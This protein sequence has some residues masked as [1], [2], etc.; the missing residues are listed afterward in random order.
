MKHPAKRLTLQ[1]D[2][3]LDLVNQPSLF[4]FSAEERQVFKA[5]AGK[6]RQNLADL[7]GGYLV[8]GLIGGT[9]VGKSSL[10]NALAGAEIASTSHRRPHTDQVLIYRHEAMN[11]ALELSLEGVP[12]RE[13]THQ[14]EVIQQ[15]LL[16]DLPDFDSLMGEHRERVLDFLEYL[17]VVVW[18]TSPEKYADKVA[19]EFLE[20]V[21]KA[22]QNFYFV[23][24]KADIFCSGETNAVDY[25]ELGRV[26]KSYQNLIREHG[27]NEPLLF[28]LSAREA[29]GSGLLESWNQF[30]AFKQQ[31]FQQRDIK[32]IT[33][34][35]TANLDVEIQ[36]FLSVLQNEVSNL[37]AYVNILENAS[38]ETAGQRSAWVRSGEEAF[39]LW[40]KKYVRPEI[41]SEQWEPAKLIGPGYLFGILLQGR[42]RR[43]NDKKSAADLSALIVPD[44]IA[45]FFQRRLE[46][47]EDRINR[48]LLQGDL[49]ASFGGQL[50]E[51]LNVPE[52][53]VKLNEEFSIIA[54]RWV[55]EPIRSSFRGFRILQTSTYL[56]ILVL[57]LFAVGGEEAWRKVLDSFGLSSIIDLLLAG[58]QTLFSSKGL[59]ALG[60]YAALTFFF[61]FRFYRRYRRSAEKVLEKTM[62]SLKSELV[63]AWEDKMTAILDDVDRF[64][65]DLRSQI[66]VISGLTRDRKQS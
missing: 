7:K 19:Y 26:T 57:F 4:S 37:E 49:P 8:I 53:S 6:L 43:S 61:G 11:Q 3:A 9:G 42:S 52:I 60:S 18:V 58:I 40:L 45:I 41:L 17:D 44:E 54:N 63:K 32:Q 39:G 10:M 30:T 48:Q 29:M 24:N 31:I 35:K 23:L 1:L 21:P 5:E 13:I 38:A 33:A 55:A 12:W 34:I 20:L 62:T 22:G 56:L 46:W 28:V 25:E 51:A 47:L 66:A 50:R 14:A 59:A 36:R 27:V 64:R 15:I 16:C 65:E 2:Q